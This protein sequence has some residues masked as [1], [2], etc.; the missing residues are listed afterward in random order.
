MLK[1]EVL[2][3]LTHKPLESSH[4]RLHH[5]VLSSQIALRHLD[6]RLRLITD[7]RLGKALDRFFTK[8]DRP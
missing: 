6:E 7:D 3:F 5:Q 8:V 1:T 2:E 4:R